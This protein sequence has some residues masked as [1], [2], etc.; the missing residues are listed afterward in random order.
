MESLD[1]RPL[2]GQ[3]GESTNS[4]HEN[5]L[6]GVKAHVLKIIK[7]YG[8]AVLKTENLLST[9]VGAPLGFDLAISGVPNDA[10]QSII[11][12]TVELFKPHILKLSGCLSNPTGS[13]CFVVNGALA[14]NI[15]LY[16]ILLHSRYFENH[17]ITATSKLVPMVQLVFPDMNNN[18]PWTDG[19]S[20]KSQK[21]LWTEEVPSI[22][23]SLSLVILGFM[24]SQ[25]YG[26]DEVTIS[27]QDSNAFITLSNSQSSNLLFL[28]TSRDS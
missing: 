18:L 2:Q 23:P 15:P 6:I 17:P 16:G 13:L 14:N 3:D 24:G 9:T 4:A 28:S 12:K 21:L 1:F 22:P 27:S 10:G 26:G 20:M 8:Y 25:T 7:E 5:N 19:Y 11:N